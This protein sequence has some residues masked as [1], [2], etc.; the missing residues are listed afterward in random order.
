MGVL[1]SVSS[2]IC[3]RGVLVLRDSGTRSINLNLQ[4]VRSCTPTH[5]GVGCDP[6]LL[7]QLVMPAGCCCLYD[8][9][10]VQARP[11]AGAQD[12]KGA[13]GCCCCE[14]RGHGTWQHRWGMQPVTCCCGWARLLYG[15]VC[16]Y[17]QSVCIHTDGAVH[18][19]IVGSRFLGAVLFRACL[20]LGTL[21]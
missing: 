20:Q 21:R 1:G 16:A 15:S 14:W 4:P 11:K 18:T 9:E 10:E 3:C 19:H 6:W 7:A 2:S 12:F 8:A 5:L 17:T 13:G